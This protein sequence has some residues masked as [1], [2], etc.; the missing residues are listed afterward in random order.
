MDNLMELKTLD[1]KRISKMAYW[2]MRDL[3]KAVYQYGMIQ[4]RDRV[5]VAVSG[6]KDSLSLLKLLDI[7]RSSAPEDYQIMAIHISGDT[8]GP[9]DPAYSP[10]T[11]WLEASG[12]EY[13]IAPLEL[14]PKDTLPLNCH[15]CTWNRKRQIFEIAKKHGCNAVALGHHADDLAQTTLM[16]LLFHGRQE[17]ITPVSDYFDGKFRLIRPLCFIPEKKL[18]SFARANQFPIQEQRCPQ[19]AESQRTLVKNFLNQ[20]DR[21]FPNVRL[22]LIKAGLND[23]PNQK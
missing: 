4:P 6:G 14:S 8:N 23:Q 18:N 1:E 7:R 11:E 3:N 13:E 9:F 10:L 16:N 20:L 15:R 21:D 5:A 2:L 22:N 12:I 17:T 19:E